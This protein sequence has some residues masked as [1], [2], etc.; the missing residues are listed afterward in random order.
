MPEIPLKISQAIIP[1]KARQLC[2]NFM[3]QGVLCNFA[4]CTPMLK[5][6]QKPRRRILY[7]K[8]RDREIEKVY[9]GLP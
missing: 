7:I 9:A 5:G 1:E 2:N 6:I 8:D 4:E 3:G